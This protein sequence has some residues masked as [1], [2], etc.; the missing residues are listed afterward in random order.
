MLGLVSQLGLCSCG[1]DYKLQREDGP[2]I[3]WYLS[4]AF[5]LD[6]ELRCL[7]ITF[8]LDWCGVPNPGR[9]QD[10][11]LRSTGKHS[12]CQEMEEKLDK[13]C[14]SAK[15][16]CVSMGTKPGGYLPFS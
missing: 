13:L 15:Q 2:C 4:G 7:G 3:A 8:P 10:A 11:N 6:I 5:F 9:Q 16:P 12:T 1:D 14:G